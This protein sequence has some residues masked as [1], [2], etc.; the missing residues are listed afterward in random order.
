MRGSEQNDNLFVKTGKL[1]LKPIVPVV[2]RRVS[3]GQD[4]YFRVA[5]KPVATL[6]KAQNTIDADCNSV[7][8]TMKGN[9]ML[10]YCLVLYLLL[11]RWLQLYCSMLI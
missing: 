10:V 3:N 6:M 4:I 9:M 8:L 2:F 11:N 5:F 1:K 7:V